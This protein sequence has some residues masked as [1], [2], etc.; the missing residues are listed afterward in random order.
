MNHFFKLSSDKEMNKLY[1]SWYYVLFYTYD[2]ESQ[3][4]SLNWQK[5]FA[6][7]IN[8]I[9]SLKTLFYNYFRLSN[10]EFYFYVNP[11]N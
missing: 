10:C 7:E 3:M 5:V 11:I 6:K 8:V 2:A 9:I 4:V 1:G